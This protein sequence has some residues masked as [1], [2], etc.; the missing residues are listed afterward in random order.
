M[1]KLSLREVRWLTKGI[2]VRQNLNPYQSDSSVYHAA[3]TT[4]RSKIM[5]VGEMTG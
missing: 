2:M 5:I 1:G 3:S 4:E